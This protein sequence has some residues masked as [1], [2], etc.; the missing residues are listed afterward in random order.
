MGIHGDGNMDCFIHL[1]MFYRNDYN[2]IW[3]IA[4]PGVAG[5]RHPQMAIAQSSM[6]RLS[7]AREYQ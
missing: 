4:K 6:R 1:G 2:N 3:D 7:A 5:R